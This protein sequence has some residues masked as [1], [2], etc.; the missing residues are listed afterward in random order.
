[1]DTSLFLPRRFLALEWDAREARVVVARKQGGRVEIEQALAID[2]RPRDAAQAA[3][4]VNIG[5]R[6]GAAL[7]VRHLG[8]METL[9]AVGR[10][11]T[12]L[13]LLTLP[14]APP[15]ELPDLVRFQAQRQFTGL[16]DDWPLDFVSLE[17]S[18]DAVSVLAATMAPDLV[19]Q[20]RAACTAAGQP[21]K[22][23]VLRPFGAAALWHRR[24]AGTQRGCQ[25]MVDLLAEEADLTVLINEQVV[26]LRTVRLGSEQTP[27]EFA[28]ALVGEV[29]RTMGAA[30]NQLSGR[31]VES[32]VLCGDSADHALI[33]TE[34][35]NVFEVPV[36]LFD[37][38]EGVARAGELA[39]RLPEHSGRYA[40]LVGLVLD[41]AAGERPAIDFLHPR[42]RPVA[43]GQKRLWGLVAGAAAA[44]LLVVLYMAWSHVAGLSARAKE[45]A[46]ESADLT[47]L[48]KRYERV[49]KDAEELAA[50][51]QGDIIWLDELRELSREAPP[52]DDVILAEVIVGSRAG[53]D[54]KI[55]LDGHVTNSAILDQLNARLTD[56]RHSVS[57]DNSG[58]DKKDPHYH[59]QF[60]QSVR[61]LTSDAPTSPA[62]PRAA[63][64]GGGK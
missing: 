31:R 51:K 3:A 26:F 30:Q 38:F 12:E 53:G 59:W 25:L 32:I 55:T 44:V 10:A 64:P 4:K 16:G 15:E 28:R 18:G 21:L 45:M 35:F 36:T 1:M 22:R 49:N 54:G 56:A 46:R 42:E 63:A 14:P 7:Q 61:V 40:P 20:I 62:K 39:D 11:S 57:T 13:R 52:A 2:L 33:K 41:E 8:Q 9:V 17:T 19:A 60:K 50:W 5:E 48:L 6:I 24:N 23:L 27:A 34:L 37:P 58:E 43:A 29:R 47:A